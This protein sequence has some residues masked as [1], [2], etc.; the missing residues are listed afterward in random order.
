MKDFLDF[1]VMNARAEFHMKTLH[2]WPECTN[3]PCTCLDAEAIVFTSIVKPLRVVC[4]WC[5]KVIQEGALEAKT[6]HT[7]CP[8]C[9][10]THFPEEPPCER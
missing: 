9:Y 10:A 4:S 8:E 6:S 1:A 3:N 7:C 2:H 5:Q